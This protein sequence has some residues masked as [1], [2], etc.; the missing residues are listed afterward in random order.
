MIPESNETLSGLTN[1]LGPVPVV[2]N[3]PTARAGIGRQAAL[4]LTALIF[5]YV[6]IYLCR[7]NLAVALPLIRQDFG[8]S[9]A[10]V[11]SIES[12]ATLAYAFGKLA[13]GPSVDH[14]GGKLCFLLAMAGVALFSGLGIFATSVLMI[15]LLYTANRFCGA[16]GWASMVKQ[17]PD[18]F[19]DRHLP[20]AMA[21][22]SLSF[23]FGGVCALVVAGQVAAMTNNSW[24][25]VLG[26]PAVV[27]AALV[28]FLGWYLPAGPTASGAGRD[29]PAATPRR[30][31][32][33]ILA[34]FKT[35]ELWVVCALSF[36]LTITRETFNVWTVDFLRTQSNGGLSIKA[37]ALLSTPFDAAGAA[38]ILLLGWVLVWLTPRNRNYLLCGTLVLLALLIYLLPQV[39]GTRLWLIETVIGLIGFLSYG[40][41]SLLAGI[42]AVEIGGRQSVA[43]V[44]ALVDSSGYMAGIA[45]G[46]FFGRILDYG[47]YHLGF[48]CLG[49]TTCVA[50]FLCL[51]LKQRPTEKEIAHA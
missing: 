34:L 19:P 45:S 35:H 1:P 14:W 13:W 48:H 2:A 43:T 5:G 17:V 46:Y 40:P 18:W 3:E 36:V 6:G 31:F 44:S 24:R 41:Y 38:G 28:I 20:L 32:R 4:R 7:K 33:R 51:A 21:F 11:G 22:L 27:L 23:V 12:Y 29:A 16:G 26:I 47:G 30:D 49:W 42:L 50:A 9:K 39:A 10:A 25:A 15:A 37:A 8:V